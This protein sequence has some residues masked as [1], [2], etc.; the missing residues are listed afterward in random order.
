MELDARY[1]SREPIVTGSAKAGLQG[2]PPGAV[3]RFGVLGPLQ[4]VDGS[5]AAFAVS[6]AKQRIVLAALLL[7]GGS[8]VSAA[9]LAEA[10]WDAAPSPNASAVVRTYVSRLRHVLGPAGA[11]IARRPA[12]FAV[13]LRALDEF[14]VAE[15]DRLR[16][17]ARTAAEVEEWEQASLLLSRALSLWRGEPLVDVPSAALSLR[18]ADRLAELRLQL[19]EARVDADLCLGRHNGLVAELRQL[20]A[21]HPLREHIRAQLMLACYRCGQQA[22]ALEVYRDA[23]DT[24]AGELGVEPGDELREMHQRVLTADPLLTAAAQAGISQPHEGQRSHATREAVVPRQL[25][26]AVSCFTGRE[27]ELAALTGLLDGQDGGRAPALV[28]SAIAGTAGIGKTALAVQWAHQVA[29]RFPGGQLYVNLRGYDR[30]EPVPAADALAGFLRALGVPG[31][32]IPDNADDRARLYRT[33]LAARRM[34]VV[35]DNARDAVQVRPLLPGNPDCM[36][37]VTSRDSLAGLVAAD[38][39]RRLDLDVLPPSEAVGLL[40]SLICSRAAADPGPLAELAGLCARL[41]LALRIAAE[42]AAARPA[43]ALPDLVSELTVARLDCLDA[44]EDRADIRALFSWSLRHLD[45]SAATAFALLGLHPGEDFDAYAAAALAGTSTAQARRVLGRLHR[46]SLLQATGPG[47]YCMHDLLREYAR[48]QADGPDTDDPPRNALTR[49]FDYYLAAT[50]VAMSVLFPAEAHR[51]PPFAPPDVAVPGMPGEADARAWLDTERP[52]LIASVAYCARHGWFDHAAGLADGMFSYLMN[53]SHL[54]DALTIY[55]HALHAGRQSA[56]LA[57]EASALNGLAGVGMLQGHVSD[58]ASRY[59]AA[60]E[61]Y[62]QC[63]D[64]AGQARVF[65]NLGCCEHFL[66]HDQSAVAYYQ[67]A[68]AA[69]EDAGDSLGSARTLIHLAG[70]ETDL[71]ANG[72]ADAHLQLALRVLRAAGD[73]LG[74]AEALQRIGELSCRRGQLTQATELFEHALAICRRIEYPLGVADGL[75]G[76]GKVSVRQTD[77]PQA[78]SYFRQALAVCRQVGHQHGEIE[79]LHRLAQALDGAEQPA[80]ARIELQAALR[81][82]AETGD[83]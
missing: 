8:T 17:A 61:L 68:I 81:L 9:R 22:A 56:D 4:V 52:N 36:A 15:A 25:P 83:T 51:H 44:G 35:L 82:A 19:T 66:R 49:L 38:G 79:M 14:D 43:V 46:A 59:Q 71:G 73:Q 2:T 54:A 20:A 16:R 1:E 50:A 5:G 11:R 13:E 53:G 3:V 7:A 23:R 39:A 45:E 41:P 47:R 18:E 26:A 10:L 29:M 55:R 42:L 67:Q 74:E 48:E 60:L 64:R 21:E 65:H 76:L 28:I 12:G 58:A 63:G 37:L 31:Q 33:K 80:D 70:A 75:T 77:Y 69:A 30:G 57:A 6:A 32:Q 24:L 78:A 62:R 40:R 72:Q 27:A 34:L